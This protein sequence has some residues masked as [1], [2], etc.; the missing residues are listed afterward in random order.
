MG[1]IMKRPLWNQLGM[2]SKY[3]KFFIS[4]I[5]L[6]IILTSC[7]DVPSHIRTSNIITRNYLD[8]VTKKYG[9]YCYGI[10]GSFR[11]NIHIIDITFTTYDEIQDIN[12]ARYLYVNLME[13]FMQEINNN[14][15]I[16][17]YLVTYPFPIEGFKMS[18]IFSDKTT[19]YFA[20][21][22][23]I[24]DV[25]LAKGNLVYST[26]D[27]ENFGFEEI[28]RESYSEAYEKVFGRPWTG[29]SI[30]LTDGGVKPSKFYW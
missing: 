15:N 25:M 7:E 12:I 19:N 26:L 24:A 17:Q 4:L 1:E 13:E 10:G 11:E 16:R 2:H 29:R 6:I 23:F 21:N 20:K 14:E 22:P 28:Y 8:K 18:I 27:K 5:F 30:Y 9:V 3:N